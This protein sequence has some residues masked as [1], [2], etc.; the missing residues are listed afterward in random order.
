MC[1]VKTKLICAVLKKKKHQQIVDFF[2]YMKT[3]DIV[4]MY[5]RFIA[6]VLTDKS[7]STIPS[8][9]NWRLIA[10]IIKK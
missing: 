1:Q 4:I 10:I 2:Q 3:L 7:S 9:L 8:Q 5:D 6:S